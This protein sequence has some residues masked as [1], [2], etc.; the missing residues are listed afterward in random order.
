MTKST[1]P[2]VLADRAKMA[3]LQARLANAMGPMVRAQLT[4]EINDLRA[5]RAGQTH[6]DDM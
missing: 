6:L 1:S 4:K 5:S 3:N 2:G